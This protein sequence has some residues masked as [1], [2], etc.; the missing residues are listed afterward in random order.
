AVNR[1][2]TRLKNTEVDCVDLI[3]HAGISG[4]APIQTGCY[5]IVYVE[6]QLWL[7]EVLTFYSK[8]AGK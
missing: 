6:G 2:N 4:V 7:S 8:G 3:G 1:Q 5:A